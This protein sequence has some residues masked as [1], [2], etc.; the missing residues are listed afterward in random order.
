MLLA[1]LFEGDR[2]ADT[3]NYNVS[4]LDD[5]D[6][7]ARFTEIA[8]MTDLDEQN[9][10]YAELDQQILELAPVVPL[11]RDT[12]LQMVGPNVG[13]AYSHTGTTGYI[14]Y[15]SVGLINPDQ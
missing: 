7:N 1:P 2:I 13:D 9:S 4:M 14:D 10:A 8:E 3:G 6:I 5:P 12:A 11:V 15:A